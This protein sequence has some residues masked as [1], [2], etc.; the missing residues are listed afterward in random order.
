MK[1][2][3]LLLL[4]IL[5]AIVMYGFYSS[6]SEENYLTLSFQLSILL[7]F[8]LFCFIKTLREKYLLHTRSYGNSIIFITIA[9]FIYAVIA[10]MTYNT[11]QDNRLKK[12]G[13]NDWKEFE[14]AQ[15]IGAKDKADFNSKLNVLRIQEETRKIKEAKIKEEQE[16]ARR[17]EEKDRKKQEQE[18]CNKDLQCIYESNS[19]TVPS[20][21]KPHIEGLAKY[22]YEWTDS[23]YESKFDRFRWKDNSRKIVTFI[24]DKLKFQNGFGAWSNMIYFCDFNIETK[25]AIEVRI[26]KGRLK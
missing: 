11:D 22:D 5:I 15:K 7:I 17:N 25:E 16:I 24:G 14:A 19:L 1:K 2:V 4:S 26:E 12:L 3:F 20:V 13:F 18:A 10:S 6:I 21:C 23:W 9:Y 8:L